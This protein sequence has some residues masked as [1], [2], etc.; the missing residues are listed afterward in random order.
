MFYKIKF[1]KNYIYFSRIEGAKEPPAKIVPFAF[2]VFKLQPFEIL[3]RTVK[4]L[5]PPFIF[6]FRAPI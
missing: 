3:L 2:I 6:V 4:K 1:Y 5:L